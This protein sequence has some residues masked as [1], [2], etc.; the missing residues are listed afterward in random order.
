MDATFFLKERTEFIRFYYDECAKAF[1]EVRRKIDEE[2]P[3]YDNPQYNEDG[4]PPFLAEW[5]D[6]DTGVDVLGLSSVSMVCDA[7]KIYFETIRIRVIRFSFDSEERNIGKQSGFVAMY[8]NA[9]SD[10]LDTDFSDC[11]V[12][13]TV[14]EQVVLARNR[15]QHGE[16]FISIVP[17]H[18]NKTLKKYPKPF[19]ADEEECQMWVDSEGSL[20]S[21]VTPNVTVS[22]EKLF[23]AM[24][25]IEDLADWIDGQM[26]KAIEWRNAQR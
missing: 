10:I 4:E 1:A 24:Q 13:F 15:A 12:D 20:S 23:A 8:K 2:L 25:H 11:P 21:L 16:E 22:R 9:L 26:D 18:D 17:R 19:F 5:I 7:L 6:A 14:I 3:P